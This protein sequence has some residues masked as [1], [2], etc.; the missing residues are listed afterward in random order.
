[1]AAYANDYERRAE[2]EIIL[3]CAEIDAKLQKISELYQECAEIALAHNL[4][5]RYTGPAGYGD[6]GYFDAERINEEPEYDWEEPTPW[7]A[8]SQS[9]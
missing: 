3:A 8:S 9:C 2:Q 5:F 7:L 4:S 6:G 1:M